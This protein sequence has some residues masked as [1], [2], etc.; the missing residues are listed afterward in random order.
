MTQSTFRSGT[1]LSLLLSLAAGGCD[2]QPKNLCKVAPG[3][4]VAKYT[5]KAAPAGSCTGVLMP[6][7]GESV[8]MQAFVPNPTDPDAPNLPTSLAIKP[9]WLGERIAEARDR[10]AADPALKNQA[11]AL[12]NYPYGTQAAPPASDLQTTRRPYAFGRFETVVPDDSGICKATAM[13]ASDL[14]YPAIPGHRYPDPEDETKMISVPEQPET[15]VKYAWSNLRVIQLP[16]SPGTQTFA[17]LT[18]TRDGCSADYTVAV[19]VPR[20]DCGKTEGGKTVANPQ[21]CDP[22]PNA[23]NLFGSGI[24]Q[25]VPTACEDISQDPASPNQPDPASPT[26][27]CVPTRTAP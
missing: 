27:V 1:W 7:R 10:A 4:G 17:D 2:Q 12:L 5:R 11:E 15:S 19:L 18:I 14:V 8:G 6:L 9:V 25:G 21:A 24:S 20:V 13:N 23:T 26:F 22:N 16:Q 3:L